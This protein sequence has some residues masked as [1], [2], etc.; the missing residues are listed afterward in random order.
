[1]SLNRTS[2]QVGLDSFFKSMTTTVDSFETMTKSAFTLS[3]KKLLPNAFIELRNIALAYFTTHAPHQKTWK[4]KRVVA[5]DGTVLNLPN[6]EVLENHF[7]I[8][9]NQFEKNMVTSRASFAFDVR[10]ELVID[11]QISH[12][13]SCE[14]ELAVSHLDQLNPQ[15][16][17]LVFDRGYPALWLFG[18]LKNRGFK[19]CFRLSTA[20]KDAVN[21]INSDENDVDWI[22]KRRSKKA[23]GKLKEY[24]IA[25]EINGLRMVKIPLSTGGVEILVTNLLS[26]DDFDLESLSELYNLR[27]GVEEAY[28]TFKNST[29]I[30]SFTGKTVHAIE[31]EFHAKTL[32]INLAS[33]L[34]TQFVEIGNTEKKGLKY[35]QK[36]NKNQVIAKTKDF[37]GHLFEHIS[38]TKLLKQ[39][40]RML[41][42]SFDII[43]PNRS[44]ERQKRT[45]K[46]RYKSNNYKGT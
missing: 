26:R 14:K 24:K 1:M 3:R 8:Q 40:K 33:M 2:V 5:I 13:H 29:H 43:R 27:W 11:A 12:G 35:D 46:T 28:K 44:F 9:K 38:L 32:L 6:S 31:Q 42:K 7:R 22:S 4:G 15:T 45:K 41:L 39:M 18:L 23:L 20:W 34:R 10:N 36:A 16:D 37:L 19:F 25:T 30:E 21:L 17:I